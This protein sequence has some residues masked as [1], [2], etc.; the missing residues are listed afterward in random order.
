VLTTLRGGS[1]AE[2]STGS[3][4]FEW[5]TAD[6]EEFAL[7]LIARDPGFGNAGYYMSRGSLDDIPTEA[8]N[9]D[10]LFGYDLNYGVLAPTNGGRAIRKFTDSN[11]L[12]AA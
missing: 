12:I 6:D 8:I 2:T 10:D 5:L 3:G 11:P 4:V 9:D 7:L 1:V